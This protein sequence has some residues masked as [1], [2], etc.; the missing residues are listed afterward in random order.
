MRSIRTPCSQRKTVDDQVSTTWQRP[1]LHATSR[2]VIRQNGRTF[3][4]E[5]T[6]AFSPH[7]W[8]EVNMALRG[9][10]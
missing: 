1:C 2:A 10:A 9:E 8:R 6:L 3:N 4:H 7:E 5:E